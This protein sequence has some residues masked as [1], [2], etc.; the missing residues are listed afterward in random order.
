MTQRKSLTQALA[1]ERSDSLLRQAAIIR[2]WADG[3]D[4]ATAAQA[5]IRESF[6]A[7]ATGQI[8]QETESKLYTVLSFAMPNGQAAATQAD[9]EA[10]QQ[11][12]ERQ[13]CPECGDG[14]CPVERDDN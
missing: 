1:N 5:L 8:T 3:P 7:W 11:Q 9:E 6:V 10:Y 4:R 12:L 13:Y 2:D 14:M